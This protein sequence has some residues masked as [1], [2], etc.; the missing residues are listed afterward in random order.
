[1]DVTCSLLS[2]SRPPNLP[3]LPTFPLDS[4]GTMT[5]PPFLLVAAALLFGRA[6]DTSTIWIAA[7]T[8]VHGRAMAWDYEH[9]R[10]A[11]VGLVRAAAAVDSLR[12]AHPGRVI[13]VDAGDLIEGNSFAR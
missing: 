6:P 9:D 11:A 12:R 13:L 4:D 8:D 3:N 5:V 10:V 7:T 1:M 2:P